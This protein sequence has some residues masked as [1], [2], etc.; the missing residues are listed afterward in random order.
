M[1]DS[2]SSESTALSY[3]CEIFNLENIVKNKRNQVDWSKNN[4]FNSFL[5]LLNWAYEIFT[6]CRKL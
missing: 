1:D 3:F 6:K 5:G 4:D 2:R